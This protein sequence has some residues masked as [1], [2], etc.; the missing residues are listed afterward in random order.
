[1]KTRKTEQTGKSGSGSEWIYG[2]NPVFEAIRA[3]RDIKRILISS[4][5]QSKLPELI[6]KA[7]ERNVPI[8]IAEPDFFDR[9]FNKGHQGVAAEV[10]ERG[11]LSL[12]EL[13]DI[14]QRK[15]EVPLFAVL[16]C[17]EDP[18]NFG[19]ILRVADAAGIHGIIIQSHRSASLSPEVSKASSGA[20]EYIPVTMVT[21][22]KH[23]LREMKE[24]GITI[25]GTDSSAKDLLWDIDLRRPIALVIGSEGKG[26]RKTVVPL[27]D[28]L[29]K[30]P[31][32]GKINS[33]N[34][35]V[36]SGIFAYEILRQRLRN[37]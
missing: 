36:A 15:N 12:E 30:I 19:A 25:I 35:S 33:L 3:G 9:T 16:D 7:D 13:F 22:I 8:K 11:Y 29:V 18:R 2:L 5:R 21:N 34:V 37:N 31:M 23:A 28:V 14:P 20:V 32:S 6:R 4:G 27:C 10:S 1:L 24:M 26:L 17:V